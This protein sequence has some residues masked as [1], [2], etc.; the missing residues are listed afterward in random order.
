MVGVRRDHTVAD[1]VADLRHALGQTQLPGIIVKLLERETRTF[2]GASDI[3]RQVGRVAAN[4]VIDLDE[5][6]ELLVI[7]GYVDAVTSSPPFRD[8]DMN[9]ITPST[10][11][12]VASLHNMVI[13]GHNGHKCDLRANVADLCNVPLAAWA[14]PIWL[15]PA[16]PNSTEIDVHFHVVSSACSLFEAWFSTEGSS[17]ETLGVRSTSTDVLSLL[18]TVLDFVEHAFV[19]TEWA[20][21]HDDDES[22]EEELFYHDKALGKSKAAIIKGVVNLASET[23]ETKSTASFWNRMRGWLEQD[24]SIRDD[25]VNCAILSFGNSIQNATTQHSLIGLLKNLSI[26]PENKLVLGRSGVM[27]TVVG[28]GV[29]SAERDALG[30]IQG[31]AIGLV[32]NL[33]K[34]NQIFISGYKDPLLA[35]L[36]RTK[37]PALRSEGTRIFVNAIKSLSATSLTGFA[38]ERIIKLLVTMLRDGSQHIILQ[39]EAIIALTL[40]ATFGPS[41]TVLQ[42]LSLGGEATRQ[43][44]QSNAKTLEYKIQN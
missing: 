21:V 31:G 18:D 5:N 35:L 25:L 29:W 26:P 43:E 27:E 36:E 7:A 33:C 8:I 30:S 4:L 41:G 13:D 32:K 20:R 2:N 9:G 16:F 40:L 28:I 39:N 12:L 10:Q 6:R 1:G 11:A 22:D 17:D 44:I 34:N 42:Q 37:D 3:V 15:Q 23:P 38:D 24:T 14:H 19:P